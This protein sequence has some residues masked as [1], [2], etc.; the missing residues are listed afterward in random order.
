M[1]AWGWLIVAFLA[2]VIIP[3]VVIFTEIV[4]FV[5]DDDEPPRSELDK[6]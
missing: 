4:R 5:D 1:V 6:V 2:G 3:F